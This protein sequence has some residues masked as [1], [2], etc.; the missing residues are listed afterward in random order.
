LGEPILADFE[1]RNSSHRN[2]IVRQ[3]YHTLTT[4]RF[5]I[6]DS[7]GRQINYCGY[8]SGVSPQ[9]ATLLPGTSDYGYGWRAGTGYFKC[10][11]SFDLASEYEILQPGR[12]QVTALFHSGFPAISIVH[13]DIEAEGIAVWSGELKSNTI[14]IEVV[15]GQTR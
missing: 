15:A 4:T 9:Y 11:K 12:Y 2:L 7:E 6:R 5:D 8:L 13:P 1:L 10:G 3:G 14:E